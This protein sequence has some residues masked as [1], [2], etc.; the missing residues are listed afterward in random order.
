MFTKFFFFSYLHYDWNTSLYKAKL[1]SSVQNLKPCH[2]YIG[3]LIYLSSWTS[4]KPLSIAVIFYS[5]IFLSRIYFNFIPLF[6]HINSATRTWNPFICHILFNI[7]C[8]IE[9]ITLNLNDTIV[10]LLII[11]RLEYFEVLLKKKKN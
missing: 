11:L 1:C 10:Q 9:C 7:I 5:F 8:F 4:F 6:L 2:Y 3:N